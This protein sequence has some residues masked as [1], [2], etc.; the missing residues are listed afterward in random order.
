MPSLTLL[1]SLAALVALPLASADAHFSH[2]RR[3]D[4]H[5]KQTIRYRALSR[6]GPRRLNKRAAEQQATLKCLSKHTFALCD[7][8][9]CT[10]MGAVAAGT[11]CI[12][13][14]I[15]WDTTDEASSEDSSS[16]SA[17]VEKPV[18]SS[19]AP[20][21]QAVASPSSSS[22]AASSSSATDM[23]A[24]NAKLNAVYTSSSASSST[25]PVAT[26][27]AATSSA[28]SNDEDDDWVCDDNDEE[29]STAQAAKSTSAP[30]SSS[31]QTSAAPSTTTRSSTTTVVPTA[32]QLV[33]TQRAS[34][35]TTTVAWSSKTTTATSAAAQTSAA[36]SSS[37]SSWVSGGDGTFYYQYGAYGA[38]GKVHQD[39]DYIVALG[40]NRYG[41][42]SN[43]APDC[44][45]QV[46]VKNTKNGKSV[47]ATVADACPGCTDSSLDLSVG[48]F[49][50]IATQAEGRVPIEWRFTS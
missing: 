35:T 14:A 20:V 30:S 1:A 31:T 24:V 47:V 8:E 7:G 44:G 46:E 4:L 23:E 42:G 45:R 13:G 41:S 40:M 38:C 15:T 22:A 9:N 21:A 11:A 39:S 19:A 16:A 28:S 48:A 27:A 49:D 33:A 43:N 34:T 36:S 25:A 26:S 17:S 37:N 18:S 50:Q 32:V 10:D 5:G 29:T 3:A 2:P 12:D 6:G